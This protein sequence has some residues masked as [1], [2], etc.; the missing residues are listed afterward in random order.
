MTRSGAVIREPGRD[1]I[2]HADID[3]LLDIPLDKQRALT[4][5]LVQQRTSMGKTQSQIA[6]EAHIDQTVIST[7]ERK[8]STRMGWMSFI[9]AIKAY[10]LDINYVLALLGVEGDEEIMPNPRIS[11]IIAGLEDLDDDWQD[12]ALSNIEV[13][14]MGL[15]QRIGTAAKR[16]R[17]SQRYVTGTP[18][19]SAAETAE[20][21]RMWQESLNRKR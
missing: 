14:L 18:E 20:K 15:R 19:D 7:L 10:G 1:I 8:I 2:A 13:W 3:S 4:N 6:E 16:R 12:Y 9:R 21:H 5:L 17:E 11:A